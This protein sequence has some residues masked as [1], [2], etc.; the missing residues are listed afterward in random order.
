M[1]SVS[2]SKREEDTGMAFNAGL[3][4][5]QLGAV[6]NARTGS[7]RP[8]TNK[9]FRV[10]QKEALVSSAHLFFLLL[11]FLAILVFL[12]TSR[13]ASSRRDLRFRQESVKQ[14]FRHTLIA[15]TQRGPYQALYMTSCITMG[16]KLAPIRQLNGCLPE[17]S[18]TTSNT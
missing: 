6:S 11:L 12:K 3:G 18:Q 2:H 10:L 15:L 8:E 17:Q 14:G 4:N 16:L 7:V 9:F 1:S 5:A 13:L